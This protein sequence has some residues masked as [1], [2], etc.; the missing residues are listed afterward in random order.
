MGATEPSRGAAVID[1]VALRGVGSL[2]NWSEHV[3]AR[4]QEAQGVL[5]QV[6]REE[7]NVD[8]ARVFAPEHVSMDLARPS[9][10]LSDFRAKVRTQASSWTKRPDTFG[11]VADWIRSQYATDANYAVVCVA[12]YSAIGDKSLE[13]R[14]H[15]QIGGSPLLVA[16]IQLTQQDELARTLRWG[17]SRTFLGVVCRA[18]KDFGSVLTNELFLCDAFDCDSLVIVPISLSRTLG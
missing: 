7:I 14:R 12:G 6:D 2:A 5:P 8:R 13:G 1:S 10:P 4:W 9:Q 11:A 15:I 17:R 18:S 16:P 3:R